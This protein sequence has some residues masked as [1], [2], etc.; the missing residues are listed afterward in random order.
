MGVFNMIIINKKRILL[1]MGI[2]L[3]AT[4]TFSMQT[5]ENEKTKSKSRIFR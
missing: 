3:I 1:M 4:F 5:F 2:L